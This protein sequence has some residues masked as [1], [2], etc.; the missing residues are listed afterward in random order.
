MRLWC[1]LDGVCVCAC[2]LVIVFCVSGYVCVSTWMCSQ[3]DRHCTLVHTLNVPCLNA[4]QAL[5][6]LL[7]C[8]VIVV[9]VSVCVTEHEVRL[10][11]RKLRV[12]SE[13][14]KNGVAPQRD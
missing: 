4:F 8:L 10:R 7:W 3:W 6:L 13:S 14:N 12:S 5:A 1:V 11:A 9:R 2:E